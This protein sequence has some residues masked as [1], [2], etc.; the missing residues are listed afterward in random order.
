DRH[1]QYLAGARVH[2]DHGP[3]RGLVLLDLCAELGLGDR[4]QRRVDR[5]PHCR[6]TDH[7]AAVALVEEHAAAHVAA[8]AYA[9]RL[10]ANLGVERALQALQ[11]VGVG[12]GEADEV[13]RERPLRIRSALVAI[14]VYAGNFEAADRVRVVDAGALREPEEVARVVAQLAV[15]LGY[16]C[17][18]Q[19]RELHGVL[20]FVV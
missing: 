1:G 18:E 9:H 15:E 14:D 16:A 4:L 11:A 12:A 5:Q 19:R 13:S 20:R 8:H 10:A 3:A 7:A 6:A 17:A 2:D